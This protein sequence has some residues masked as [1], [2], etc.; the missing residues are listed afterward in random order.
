MNDKTTHRRKQ[1][2]PQELIAAGLQEFAINGFAATRM[3]DIAKRAGV[4]KGTIYVYFESK[5]ALFEAAVRSQILPYLDQVGAMVLTHKGSTKDLIRMMINMMYAKIVQSNA[6]DIIRVMIAEG[7]K[8]PALVEFYY[9]TVLEKGL[10]ILDAIVQHGVE[11][12]EI[13]NDMILK[14]PRLLV[15]PIIFAGVWSM[16]FD[17]IN[18]I[19]IDQFCEAH[20]DVLFNGIFA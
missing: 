18:P 1:H 6:R 16:V 14:E 19:N 10:G 11:R 2:R 8:F 5:E 9:N 13:K 20:L 12:G 4:S 15:A 3:I 17:E 7:R